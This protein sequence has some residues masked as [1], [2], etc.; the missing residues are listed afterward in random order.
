M[1][2][3]Y[4][5]HNK[6]DSLMS[7]RSSHQEYV[8]CID[9]RNRN[10]E[11]YPEPNDV[12]LDI[13]FSR[14]LPVTRISLGSIELPLPQYIIE[15]EWSRIYLS[16][17]FAL[18]VNSELE[19]CLRELTVR[20]WDGSIVR[21]TLPIWLN[22]IVDIDTSDPTS[23]IF[24]TMFAHAL[25]LR[26]EWD[27]GAPIRLISTVLTDPTVINMTENNSHLEILS[28]YMFRLN[29]IP[30]IP[31]LVLNQG[32]LHAP[33]IANPEKLANIVTAGLNRNSLNLSYKMVFDGTKNQFCLRL[34]TFPCALS[35]APDEK[36]IISSSLNI[37]SSYVG[38]REV[39]RPMVSPAVIIANSTN[40]LSFIMGFG[41]TDLPLPPGEESV[42]KGV[43]GEFCY[44]CMSFIELC[45]GNYNVETFPAQFSTQ[46]NRF[47]FEPPCMTSGMNPISVPPPTLV[48]SDRCGMCQ[49]VHIPFGK[50]SPETL[51]QVLENAM[52]TTSSTNDYRVD[53]DSKNGKFKFRTVSGA[54][55]GLE[56]NDPRNTGLSFLGL[57]S[58]ARELSMNERLGFINGCYSGDNMYMSNRTFHV[59]TKGCKCT[60][61]PE[62][63][64]SNIYVPLLTRSK[65]EFGVNAC[66]PRIANGLLTDLGN[67]FVRID[68]F[69]IPPPAPP[70]PPQYA[71]GFQPEDVINVSDQNMTYQLVVAEIISATSFLAEISGVSNLVGVTDLMVCISLFGPVIFNL[72]FGALC[73]V[74]PFT[75]SFMDSTPYATYPINTIRAEI[76]GFPPTAILWNGMGSLPF[77]APNQFNLDPPPYLLIELVTPNESRYIQHT[78]QNDTITNLLAKII[79]YPQL[80]Q[81]RA[82]PQEV[83]F[84]GL[85]VINQLHIRILNPNHTL[86]HFHGSDWSATMI[87]IVSGLTGAQ[88]CY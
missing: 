43:C 77:F 22:P 62:R 53:Y 85:K 70:A 8:V 39:A 88:S 27:W 36:C 49:V 14:G 38:G 41:C 81:E 30:A 87:F 79:A 10:L 29:D 68:T 57:S 35:T 56:F 34:T 4:A 46:A 86:Y 63:L 15:K 23:P 21:A 45:P 13:N 11:F 74:S 6:K 25:G 5:Y 73:N 33:A 44:Q 32:Y 58:G 84:Q 37:S 48:F 16:E 1:K 75:Q 52:N 2:I 66:R 20:E 40:C 54:L 76:T 61:I 18:I 24:M 60:T 42:T 55:F 50:Y 17:G 9:S 26:G 31:P 65:K 78:F 19:E 82:V 69:L 51:A 83:N 47:Y 71:H 80:R 67:G 72:F 64:L 12:K 59:P 7:Q 3:Y 28:P